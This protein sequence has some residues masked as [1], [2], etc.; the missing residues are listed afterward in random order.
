MRDL[1]VRPVVIVIVMVLLGGSGLWLVESRFVAGRPGLIDDLGRTPA[2]PQDFRLGTL[3]GLTV[4]QAMDVVGAPS[5][6]VNSRPWI[7]PLNRATDVDTARI[8]A[9]CFTPASRQLAVEVANNDQ[10]SSGDWRIA[11]RGDAPAR[12]DR[13]RDVTD[14]TVTSPASRLRVGD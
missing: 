10:L 13:L 1:G 5:E 2:G 12:V 6:H 8:S 14:C 7:V 4:D 3:L 9:A 11:L